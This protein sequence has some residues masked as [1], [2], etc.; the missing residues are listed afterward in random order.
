M[1]GDPDDEDEDFPTLT[2]LIDG[3]DAL[4]RVG[5]SWFKGFEAAEI[6]GPQS[7]S[8]P[9]DPGRRVAVYR[10]VCGFSDDGV[11]APMIERRVDATIA[12]TDFRDYT[13]VFYGPTAVGV[14]PGACA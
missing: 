12:W 5:D 13:G 3:Y 2:V 1:I 11:V 8:L 10:F 14:R 9:I 6:L 4:H 7:P